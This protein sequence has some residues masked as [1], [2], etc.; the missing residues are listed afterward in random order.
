VFWLSICCRK[1]RTT[2]RA[3]SPHFRFALAAIA[4]SLIYAVC[5]ASVST[6]VLA[7]P[8]R[9]A[10][11]GRDYSYGFYPWE[12]KGNLEYRWSRE[13]AVSVIAVEGPR[14]QLTIW[15]D[16]PDVSN[17]PVRVQIWVD[18]QR[19]TDLWLYDRLPVTCNIQIPDDKGHIALTLKVSS[20]WHPSDYGQPDHRRLGIAVARWKF[21]QSTD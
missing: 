5:L 7:V 3:S 14:M 19:A 16:Q 15:T 18:S 17:K 21:L 13:K 20:T 6:G 8:S 11:T 10:A 2:D 12:R 1:T 4:Y 9:A